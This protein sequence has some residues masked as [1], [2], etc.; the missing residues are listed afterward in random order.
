LAVATLRFTAEDLHLDSV[1]AILC[2]PGVAEAT[3]MSVLD[4]IA[5]ID[6]EFLKRTK[7]CL[8]E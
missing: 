1:G 2:D 7:R 4:P 8:A 6:A 3:A 5:D